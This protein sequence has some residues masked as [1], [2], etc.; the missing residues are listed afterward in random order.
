MKLETFSFSPLAG[1][2]VEPL[3]DFDSQNTLVVVFGP[4]DLTDVQQPLRELVATYGQSHIVGCSTAGEIFG[5]A[6]TD[7]SLTVAVAKFER[8]TRVATAAASVER[9]D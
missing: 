8:G 4:P 6:L 9:Q 3:P 7:N 2:S 1:W 5:A